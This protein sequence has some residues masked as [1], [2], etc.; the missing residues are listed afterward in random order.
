MSLNE[1]ESLRN[2][3][4]VL[5]SIVVALCEYPTRCTMCYRDVKNGMYC[6]KCNNEYLE[7]DCVPLTSE[8]IVNGDE[9]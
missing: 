3:R 5:Q 9:D 7:C 4:D 8:Q 6:S 2:E 1:I